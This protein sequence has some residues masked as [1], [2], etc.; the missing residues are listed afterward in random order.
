MQRADWILGRRQ[1]LAASYDQLLA[2]IDWLQTPQVPEN[3]VHGYQAYV[4]LFRPDDVTVENTPR[5]HEQ[6]NLVMARLEE[7]GIATR[8]GTH[9]PVLSGYYAGKYE[10][11]AEQFPGA[12]AGD[13]LTLGLPLYPQMTEADQ[14]RVV[15]ELAQ[16]FVSV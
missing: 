11:R 8:Q 12:Y 9:A 2:E 1:E 13:R 10:L 14:D 7:R 15:T 3:C 4:C 6:R 16:A 5:L